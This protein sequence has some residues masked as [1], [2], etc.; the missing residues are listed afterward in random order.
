MSKIKIFSLGGLN[1]KG[2]NMYVVE[3]DNDIFVFDAGSK[4]AE[5]HLLG[6]DYIIPDITYLKENVDR[7]KGIFI[8][9]PHDEHIG[10]LPNIINE[11]PNIKIYGTKFTVDTIKRI[12]EELKISTQ[13]IIEISAHK[14]IVFKDN[15]IFPISLTHSVPESV[16]Y[17]LNT[18]DGAIFYTG[19]FVFD[20]TMRGPYKTDIGKLAYIGKQGVLCLLSESIY[21]D[22]KGYTSPNHRL[23]GLINELL[24]RNEDRIIFHVISTNI[25]RLQELFNEVMKTQR[26]VVIMGKRLQKI[27]NYVLDTGYVIFDRNRIGDLSNVN[28]KDVLIL[29]SSDNDKPFV[30]IEKILSGYDKFINIKQSDTFVFI[31]PIN[32]DLEKSAVKISDKIAKIGPDV[33]ILST[34]KYLSHHASSE[35]LMLMLDLINPKYYFPVIGEYRYQVENADIA[36]T[37]GMDKANILLKENG[38]VSTFIDGKIVDGFEKVKVG[39]IMIDGTSTEDVGELVIKDREMLSDNGILIV[40]A[41]LD[42]KT[43]ALL[44]GPEIITRGF[45]YVKDNSEMIKEVE[46]ISMKIINQNISNNYVDYNNIKNSI[47]DEVGRFLYEETETRPMIISVMQEI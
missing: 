5:G 26:K 38:D 22:R 36:Y 27:V 41:T 16:G 12:L 7:V 10:A 23:S 8:T 11:L 2:K 19:N 3:V 18:K 28:D 13:N 37:I 32:D 39:N 43:K 30:N 31:E 35:D 44:A 21:S 4:Y 6:I 1:E 40:S 17:V 33:V 47:R 46:D 20:S 24:I 14:K 9:H 34:D 45:I 15:S 25:F 29:T 42:K